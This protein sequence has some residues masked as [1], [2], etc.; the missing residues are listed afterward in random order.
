MQYGQEL[1]VEYNRSLSV[2]TN[3]QKQETSFHRLA[4]PFS[5]ILPRG[6]LCQVCSPGTTDEAT[7]YKGRNTATGQ[8]L[9]YHLYNHMGSVDT[10]VM[11]S[12]NPELSLN[13]LPYHPVV[14][15]SHMNPPVPDQFRQLMQSPT[16]L[17]RPCLLQPDWA[18]RF[19]QRPLNDQF[20]PQQVERFFNQ[21]QLQED[22]FF[23]QQVQQSSVNV[24]WFLVVC[25]IGDLQS[26]CLVTTVPAFLLQIPVDVGQVGF[27]TAIALQ[28]QHIVDML[29]SSRSF[30]ERFRPLDEMRP[31][32]LAVRSQNISMFT[33]IVN[34]WPTLQHTQQNTNTLAMIAARSPHADF[35]LYLTE[36]SF[37]F[38]NFKDVA[39]VG[40]RC[41][42]LNSDLQW[43]NIKDLYL[44]LY[45]NVIERFGAYDSTELELRQGFNQRS[46]ERYVNNVYN[47]IKNKASKKNT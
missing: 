46:W 47:Q 22:V 8:T 9:V 34:A 7:F 42:L 10:F 38:A 2:M 33:S 45:R 3:R 28:H 16:L 30:M 4:N 14:G 44:S 37:R 26:I 1:C 25:R 39:T 13:A 20:V 36:K 32:F 41:Q 15:N 23:G 19:L 24:H 18:A 11:R 17:K 35:V 43:I 12:V 40:I 31:F 6:C 27:D 5:G 29:V 21:A